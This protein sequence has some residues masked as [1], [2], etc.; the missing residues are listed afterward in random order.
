MNLSD[1]ESYARHVWPLQRRFVRKAARCR[2]CVVSERYAPLTDGICAACERYAAAPESASIVGVDAFDRTILPYVGVGTRHDAIVLLSGGKDSAYVANLMQ[3]RYP[4]LRLL[5]V[6]IDTGFLSPVAIENAAYAAGQLGLDHLVV[7]QREQF[8]VALRD[9]F[10]GLRNGGTAYAVVDHAEGSLIFRTG[11]DVAERLGVPLVIGGMSWAQLQLITGVEGFEVSLKG[12]ARTLFPLAV[13][14]LDETAIAWN[15]LTLGLI[16]PGQASPL[17]TNSRL[18]PAM[19]VADFRNLGYCSFEP[20]FAQL[21]REGKAPR[22]PWLH[23]F[24]AAEYLTR[25]GA[26]DG[27]ASSV[28]DELGLTLDDVCKPPS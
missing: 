1:L 22:K 2:R 16:P 14:R 9:A 5:A 4:A 17:H 10:A 19:V 6:T 28:L 15:V 25:A 20:E 8:A 23:I 26:L 11:H 7:R 18:L 3:S 27:E 21:V 13:W 12:W 24:E